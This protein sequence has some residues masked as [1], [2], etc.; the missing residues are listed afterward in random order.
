[1]CLY[2]D[3]LPIKNLASNRMAGIPLA[4]YKYK[5]GSG[6]HRLLLS[7]KNANV[8]RICILL[9]FINQTLSSHAGSEA[10]FL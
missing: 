9:Y 5:T 2:F 8:A 7:N 1:M 10:D 4:A 3:G 6:R